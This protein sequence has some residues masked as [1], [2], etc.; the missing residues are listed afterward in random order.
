MRDEQAGSKKM[1]SS[2]FPERTKV[3]KVSI[4]GHLGSNYITPR[5]L[6][7]PHINKFVKVQGI[8][9]RMTVVKAKI[10]KSYHFI[11]KTKQGHVQG[12]QD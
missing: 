6:K 1:L 9:T 4:E 2:S 5:G 10:K 12:F 3:L 7:A 8:V 11:E